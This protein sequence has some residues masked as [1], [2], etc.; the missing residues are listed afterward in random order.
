MTTK[1][2]Y[3]ETLAYWQRDWE[4]RFTPHLAAASNAMREQYL[5]LQQEIQ[6][7]LKEGREQ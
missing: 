3:R 1:Q 7:V 6:A 5:L 2:E 4:K